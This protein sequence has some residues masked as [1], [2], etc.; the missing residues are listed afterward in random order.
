MKDRGIPRHG[1]EITMQGKKIGVVTTGYFS[2]TLKKNIG[3]ALIDFKYCAL[4]YRNR[5]CY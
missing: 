5:N 4:R 1:C 3:L 2:P